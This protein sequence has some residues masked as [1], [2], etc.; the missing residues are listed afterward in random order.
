[1]SKWKLILH[2]YQIY[3]KPCK[4]WVMICFDMVQNLHIFM[5]L[6][7]YCS[8][9]YKKIEKW[10]L[11]HWWPVMS[12][13]VNLA[14]W[15]LLQSAMRKPWESTWFRHCREKLMT[16]MTRVSIIMEI[17]KILSKIFITW[18]FTFLHN[19]L[20][21]TFSQKYLTI[22]KILWSHYSWPPSNPT[23]LFSRVTNML[24]IYLYQ[25]EM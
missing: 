12:K 22:S 10:P 15:G 1:M 14:I 17:L 23:N 16:S 20:F 3:R 7:F 4:N 18:I 11:R 13:C 2:V 5:R 8:F 21:F 25:L 24:N 19:C 9:L 6:L